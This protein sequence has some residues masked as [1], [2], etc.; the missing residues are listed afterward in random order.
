MMRGGISYSDARHEHYLLNWNDQFIVDPTWQ[1][2]MLSAGI[3]Y[4]HARDLP[5]EE[6]LIAPKAQLKH[7]A[8]YAGAWAMSHE[9]ALDVQEMY[10]D[11]WNMRVYTPACFFKQRVEEAELCFQIFGFDEALKAEWST[12]QTGWPAAG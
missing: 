2:F 11:I 1:Q 5:E 3:H 4:R 8:A 6:V 7:Y 9:T 12:S 10:E